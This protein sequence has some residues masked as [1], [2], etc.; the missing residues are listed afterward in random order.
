MPP[1][2]PERCWT[3]LTVHAPRPAAEAAG[4]VL[5][6]QCPN[7]I[8]V[9]DSADEVTLTGYLP[10]DMDGF[11]SRSVVDSVHRALGAI[12]DDLLPAPL[13]VKAEPVP[14]RDWIEVFRSQCQ[15]VREGRIVVKPTWEPWPSPGLEAREDD[16]VIELDPGLAFG[17][18]DHQTT[19]GCLGALQDVVEPGARVVDFGCGSGVLSIAALLLGAGE[20]LAIDYDPV[21][22]AV[23]RA[24]AARNGLADR[25]RLEQADRLEVAGRGWDVI[26]A[27]I[28]SQVIVAAAPV[29][30]QM[31]RGGGIFI[32]AGIP[33]EHS[34][35]VQQALREAGFAG[36]SREVREQWVLYTATAPKEGR[37]Q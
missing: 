35:E 16:L 33:I 25:L 8:S 11:D 7:G 12:P 30:R 29:A 14:E 5:L 9:S 22:V 21:A 20:V 24:N 10:P 36:I 31:L 1:D 32:C 23:T 2:Q 19:R 26:V 37:D 13:T 27:N 3:R 34:A 17:S 28:N 15:A 6:E 18:G 4:A